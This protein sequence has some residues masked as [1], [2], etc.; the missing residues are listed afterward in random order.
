MK[1]YFKF[2]RIKYAAKRRTSWPH[3]DIR[4]WR[5]EFTLQDYDL[6]QLKDT[7]FLT[8]S[9]RNEGGFDVE[10]GDRLYIKTNEFSPANYPLTVDL[11][12]KYKLL[13]DG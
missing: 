3:M 13:S 8:T 2:F 12:I 9:M 10:A 11:A 5:G 1:G 6:A 4:N 7:N